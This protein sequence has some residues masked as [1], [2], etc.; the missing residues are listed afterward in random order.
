MGDELDDDTEGWTGY[1]PIDAPIPRCGICGLSAVRPPG[2]TD[3]RFQVSPY[4]AICEVCAEG[5]H[6]RFQ[7]W[8]VREPRGSKPTGPYGPHGDLHS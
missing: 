7:Q 2:P 6:Q 4:G 1:A 8:E 3:P 5:A